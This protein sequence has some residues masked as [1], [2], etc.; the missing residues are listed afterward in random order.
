MRKG[1]L[2]PILGGAVAAGVVGSALAPTKAEADGGATTE[3]PPTAETTIA[4]APLTLQK[5]MG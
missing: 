2:A 4:E 1:T 5:S 3:A